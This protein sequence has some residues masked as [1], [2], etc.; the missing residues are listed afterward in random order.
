MGRSSGEEPQEKFAN[1]D[2]LNV[3]EQSDESIKSANVI[4]RCRLE[5]IEHE[6]GMRF[7]RLKVEKIYKNVGIHSVRLEDTIIIPTIESNAVLVLAN[8]VKLSH[9]LYRNEYETILRN[10]TLYKVLDVLPEEGTTLVACL[11]SDLKQMIWP[12]KKQTE[13]YEPVPNPFRWVGEIYNYKGEET[14]RYVESKLG[15]KN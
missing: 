10:L 14:D 8:N 4:V 15:H 9:A 11:N 13:Y 5:K 1:L 3:S 6:F 2:T 7:L 12:S